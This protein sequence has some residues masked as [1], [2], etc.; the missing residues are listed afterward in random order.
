MR[1]GN[2]SYLLV[3]AVQMSSNLYSSDKVLTHLLGF[4]I[5][6]MLHQLWY[7]S[8][9]QKHR[10]LDGNLSK[11]LLNSFN[12]KGNLPNGFRISKCFADKSRLV[13]QR[14][15]ICYLA[16]HE[17]QNPTRDSVTEGLKQYPTIKKHLLVFNFNYDFTTCMN[18][19]FR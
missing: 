5:W 18:L 3:A 13:F 4:N 8:L 2:I 10:F 9:K 14:V 17:S 16:R 12:L 19:L 1:L 7:C 15:K 11:Y 6:K